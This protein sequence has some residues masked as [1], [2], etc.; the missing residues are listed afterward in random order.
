MKP[1]DFS[2][3]R[4][5]LDADLVRY[6][7]KLGLRSFMFH[8]LLSPGFQ[9]S[10][11]MRTCSCSAS[12]P[13]LRFLFPLAWLILRHYEFKYGIA[14]SY[15]T[16]IGGGLYIGHVGGIVVNRQ[17]IIGANCNLSHQVTLGVANR[18]PRK[19]NPIIGDNVYIGPGAKVIGNICIGNHAAIGANCVVTKDV[20]EMGVVVGIPGRVISYK[21]SSGYINQ[22]MGEGKPDGQ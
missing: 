13:F 20:P 12:N 14:I 22:T 10:F 5:L 1:I 3:Y 7:G 9:Y 15:Q 16:Q 6:A 17:V 4:S 21:G 8:I 19:G 11:W 2:A 18:G